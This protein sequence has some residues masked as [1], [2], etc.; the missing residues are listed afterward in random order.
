[1][2]LQLGQAISD[3]IGRVLTKTGVI[4]FAGLVSIQLL[5]QL[6]ANTAVAGFLPPAATQ[7]AGSTGLTLPVSPVVGLGLGL[8]GIL[9]SAV[10]FVVL[11]RA[12]SRPQRALSTLPASLYTRRIGR[13]TITALLGGLVAS[14]AV[15]IGFVLLVVPGIF[16]SVSFLFFIFAV[17]VEDR[18]VLGSL[19][20][21]WAMARGN[22]LK[23][24]LLVIGVGVVGALVGTLGSVLTL[25]GLGVVS[26]LLVIL[27][28][29][30][31]FMLLYGTLAAAYRQLS[32]AAPTS[33][34]SSSIDQTGTTKL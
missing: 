9:A 3:G 14:V 34:L 33:D 25:A 28:N 30:S 22:R 24:A 29:S 10:Y 23:I 19:R 11:S 4:L 26:E 12:L 8:I 5:T 18:G 15:S 7:A 2:A 31:V 21:S 20:R 17:G 32:E 27:I 1:M 16:L 6:G 13:A